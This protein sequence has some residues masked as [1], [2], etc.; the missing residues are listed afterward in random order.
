[1]N[2]KKITKVSSQIFIGLSIFSLGSVSILSLLNPQATMDLV[3]TTL[4]NTDAMSSI[5]GVYGGVGLVLCIQLAYLLLKDIQKGLVF[6]SIFWGAYAASRLLTI[7]LDGPLGDF[8]N[9]WII[10]ESTFSLIAISL[11]FLIKKNK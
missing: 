11:L 10:I 1:M 7:M 5:R 6:L 4:P 9:Q 3:Q 8:G 2:T